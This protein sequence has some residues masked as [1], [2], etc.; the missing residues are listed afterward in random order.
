MLELERLQVR[1]VN[2]RL[3]RSGAASDSDGEASDDTEGD[4]A[5]AP[6]QGTVHFI[7]KY[8]SISIL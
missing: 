1:V 8:I 6:T 7:L 2:G 5:K 3:G 4:K